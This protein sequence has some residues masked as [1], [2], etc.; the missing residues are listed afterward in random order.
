MEEAR[1][2]VEGL[3]LQQLLEAPW[4]AFHGTGVYNTSC[5]LNHSCAPSLKLANLAS[6]RM[7]AWALLPISPGELSISYIDTASDVQTRRRQLLEYGFT[8]NCSKCQQEDSTGQRKAQ[9]R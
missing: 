8:C 5:R 7:V 3:S 9:K 4:P 2:V 6:S 1:R